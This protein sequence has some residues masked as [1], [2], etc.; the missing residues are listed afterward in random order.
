MGDKDGQIEKLY[1]SLVSGDRLSLAKSI[2]LVESRN[3]DHIMLAHM[4]V[5]KCISRSQSSMRIGT[6]GTPGVGKSTFIE[7]LAKKFIQKNNKVAVL[8]IDPTSPVSKGSILGDKSRMDYLSNS[9]LAFVRSSPSRTELGGTTNNTRESIL[10]CETAGFEVVFIETVGVGQSEVAISEMVDLVIL[11]VQ[12]GSGDEIQGIKRGIV[13]I[14]D[15][16]VINKS[17]QVSE[18]ILNETLKTFK[19][20]MHLQHAKPNKWVPKVIACSAINGNGLDEIYNSVVDYFNLI[21]K[22]RYLSKNRSF[23]KKLW[24]EGRIEYEALQLI[25]EKIKNSK[26]FQSTQEK[27]M[28][29]DWSVYQAAKQLVTDLFTKSKD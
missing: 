5:S 24:L 22:S 2:T 23:Q 12:P 21:N 27:V 16:I 6:T 13:E 11:L 7:A 18:S 17:D 1:K 8:T 10:L 25:K 20:A 28:K 19:F 15:F 4:L 9:P 3:P 26:F 14:A 29:G